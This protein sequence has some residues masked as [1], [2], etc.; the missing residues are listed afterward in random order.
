[1]TT[2][3]PDPQFE[4]RPLAHDYD[5]I[6]EYDNPAPFWLTRTFYATIVFAAGYVA[7]YHLG[8]PGVSDRQEFDTAWA[9]HQQVRSAA[10]ATERIAVSEDIFAQLATS[11]T[12]L[13]AGKAVFLENC[14]SCHTDNGRGL[15]GPNLTDE[16]QIHG[17]GRMDIYH[18]IRDGVPPKGMIAWGEVLP[19][20][21]LLSVSA[22]VVS[23]RGTNAPGGKPPEGQRVAAA[24]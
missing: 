12:R 19:Y 15:V 23:L 11:P 2:Q 20:D 22:Y 5:G 9:A 17:T 24:P 8:G 7:Y 21:D 14:Q 10:A 6:D 1:M 18:T 3:V 13:E 4:D 16:F